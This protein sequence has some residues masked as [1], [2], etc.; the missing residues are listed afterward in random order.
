M[1]KLAIIIYFVSMS[2]MGV[3]QNA[4]QQC[5]ADMD[6]AIS[7]VVENKNWNDSIATRRLAEI[8]EK[9]RTCLEGKTVPAFETRTLRGKNIRSADWKG[10]VVVINF[11]FTTCPPC[12]SEM[13]AFNRLSNEYKNRNVLFLGITFSTKKD[14][15]DFLKKRPF[16]IN[17][18]PDADSIEKIFAVQQHPLTLI[19]D[20][21]GLIQK[22]IAGGSVGSKA[23]GEAYDKIKPAIDALLDKGKK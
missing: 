21:S 10:K 4:F 8:T 18:A 2:L 5:A 19:V 20:Q 15:Q 23:P 22:A 11:W 16:N 3:G 13:P 17:I 1:L 12:V 14:V 9:W 7:E 6:R